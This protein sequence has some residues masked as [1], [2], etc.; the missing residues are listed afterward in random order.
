MVCLNLLVPGDLVVLLAGE[1]SSLASFS[2]QPTV[3]SHHQ[4]KS[5]NLP[6]GSSIVQVKDFPV[7]SVIEDQLKSP[8]RTK[9]VF[10]MLHEKLRLLLSFSIPVFASLNPSAST[11]LIILTSPLLEF[12]WWVTGSCYLSLLS[13]QLITSKTPFNEAQ[14]NDVD[15]FD[16]DAPPPVKNIKVPFW[17]IGLEVLKLIIYSDSRDGAIL[18][19]WDGDVIEALALTSVL[20]FTDREGPISNVN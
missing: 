19:F 6:P 14:T 12:V 10:K 1:K 5:L 9:F 16:E 13:K 11:I 2:H 3:L 18:R 15:E 8:R 4:R 20:C 17:K 7:A